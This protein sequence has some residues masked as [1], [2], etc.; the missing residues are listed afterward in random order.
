MC[1]VW[2]EHKVP[3]LFHC[4]L[5]QCSSVIIRLLFGQA[6]CP[7]IME[8][9]NRFTQKM[10]NLVLNTQQLSQGAWESE[11]SNSNKEYHFYHNV[12]IF[13][14]KSH[15]LAFDCFMNNGKTQ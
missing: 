13:K 1:M 14:E 2:Y 10:L 6:E 7:N 5:S 8:D 15:Q 4:L 9:I 3:F 12:F 11:E